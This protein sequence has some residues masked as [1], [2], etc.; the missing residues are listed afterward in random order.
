MDQL[1]DCFLRVERPDRKSTEPKKKPLAALHH[2]HERIQGCTKPPDFTARGRVHG[3]Q[4]RPPHPATSPLLCCGA[5]EECF[6]AGNAVTKT[7]RPKS[8]K[9]ISDSFCA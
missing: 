4:I 9:L 7:T 5:G 3:F 1:R 8:R 6:L 2:R